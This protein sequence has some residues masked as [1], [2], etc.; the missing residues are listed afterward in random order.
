[1][2]KKATAA[3]PTKIATVTCQPDASSPALFMTG[4]S[5]A[6]YALYLPT[7]FLA[8]SYPKMVTVSPVCRPSSAMSSEGA[9]FSSIKPSTSP[10]A[11]DLN[12]GLG[13]GVVA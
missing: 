11:R 5:F 1:M 8:Q 9:S 7:Y 10:S 6:L 13:L 4:G 3:I 2:T 12:C